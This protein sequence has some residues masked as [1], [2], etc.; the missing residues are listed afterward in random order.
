MTNPKPL[1]EQDRADLVAEL[2][3]IARAFDRDGVEFAL[4]G[5][6]AVAVHGHVRATKDIDLLVPTAGR[7]ARAG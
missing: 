4:C 7:D 2:Q 6:L 1:S 3:S 5:G